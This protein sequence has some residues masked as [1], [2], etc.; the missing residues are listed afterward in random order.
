[1]KTVNTLTVVTVMLLSLAGST[2]ADLV[3]HYNFDRNINDSSGHGLHGAV[4]GEPR[5][6]Y[7]SGVLGDAIS[8]DGVDDYVDCGNDR[9]FDITDEITVAAWVNITEASGE[10]R[11]VI[12]KGDSAWRLSTSQHGKKYY[13]GVGGP[14]D[15]VGT[16]GLMPV[17]PGQWHHI[18]GTYD[19]LAIRLYVDGVLDT[20]EGYTKGIGTNTHPVFIGENAE[21]MGRAW[22]GLIDDVRIYNHKLSAQDIQLIMAPEEPPVVPE[23]PA[24][25]IDAFTYQGRLPEGTTWPDGIYDLQF[26]LYSQETAG[27]ILGDTN[28]VYDVDVIHGYYTVILDFGDGV[29]DGSDRWLDI[30]V[31][32]GNSSGGF[33]PISPRYLMTPVPYALYA[34]NGVGGTG[35]GRYPRPC[36]TPGAERGQG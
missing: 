7:V 36:R 16:D 31:R 17:T 11:T 34:F 12:A 25:K 20:S 15:W 26:E 14:P 28:I 9:A 23:E 21:A 18:A 4:R 32:A 33:T 3:A 13:F 5:A 24:V 8:L 27:S 10:W 22:P 6:I 1:M 19:G 2:S 29:F 35:D 30:D